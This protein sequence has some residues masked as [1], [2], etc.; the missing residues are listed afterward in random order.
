MASE[1]M[2]SFIPN[3]QSVKYGFTMI[4]IEARK[5]NYIPCVAL[6]PQKIRF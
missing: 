2:T 3:A 1:D 5:Y 4:S 6:S